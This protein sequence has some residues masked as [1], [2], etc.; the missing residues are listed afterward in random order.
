MPSL[1]G[2][3]PAATFDH[4]TPTAYGQTTPAP[5]FS[6]GGGVWTGGGLVMN[7]APGSAAGLYADPANDPTNYLAVL[8]GRTETVTYSRLE[9]KL[10]LYWGSIDSYNV[11]TLYDGA[12]SV[13]VPVPAGADGDQYA[14]DSNRYFVI[15]G[16]DFDE[17]AFSS[18]GN[19]FEFDNVA[20]AAAPEP[21]IWVLLLA[22][23]VG[24]ALRGRVTR[25]P[26]G[27]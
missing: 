27:A 11:V 14:P 2:F 17:V 23:F 22:G 7:N 3:G 26:A 13:T 19:S 24:L 21:S 18:G 9:S 12:A 8:G 20:A 4:E 1:S 10:G 25:R 5:T 16:F 6:D 15:S